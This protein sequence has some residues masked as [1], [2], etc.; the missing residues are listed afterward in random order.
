MKSKLS[1]LK[2][3]YFVGFLFALHSAIPYFINSTF[4]S[5]VVKD[6]L[7]ISQI[8]QVVSAIYIFASFVTFLLFIK[9]PKLLA[10]YGNYRTTLVLSLLNIISVIGLAYM[11]NIF[12]V[13]ISFIIFYATNIIISYCLDIFIEHNSVPEETG[14]IRTIDLTFINLAWIFGP[15]IAGY[16]LGAE[17]FSKVFLLSSLIMLPVVLIIAK[18]MKNMT[19]PNYEHFNFWRTLTEVKQNKNV[20]EIFMTNFILQFFY[21]WMVIYIPI[22]LNIHLGFD[23][24]A[25]GEILT[26]MLIPFVLIQYP[27]GILA[28]KR[29]GEKEMLTMGFIIM[30]IATAIIPLFADTSFWLWAGLLFTTRIG[31]AMVEAMNDVYFFKNIGEKDANIISLY[32]TMSPIAYVIA[33]I[34]GIVLLHFFSIHYIFYALG[35]CMLIGVKYSLSLRDTL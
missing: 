29:Y 9:A 10:K 25:I 8:E 16:L 3:L 22:Y 35:L 6:S 4:L 1:T 5:E 32:R 14:I 28:D 20:R 27:I 33:P 18:T 26:I 13:L 23:W 34:I 24:I 15:L 12:F 11:K 17:S 30:A 2:I 7:S 31:A 21:V 19:D